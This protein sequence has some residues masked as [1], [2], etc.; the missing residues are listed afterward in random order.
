MDY[1]YI[2]DL[3]AI[4]EEFPQWIKANTLHFTASHTPE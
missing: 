2:R 1:I 3:Y 4:P